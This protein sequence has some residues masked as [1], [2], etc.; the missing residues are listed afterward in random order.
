MRNE[1]RKRF[2]SYKNHLIA[3]VNPTCQPTRRS[4]PSRQWPADPWLLDLS[5]FYGQLLRAESFSGDP[6]CVWSGPVE[7]VPAGITH[8]GHS[9][10]NYCP[11]QPTAAVILTGER[12]GG[13]NRTISSPYQLDN[14]TSRRS[15][16]VETP[17][18]RTPR[19]SVHARR[20]ATKICPG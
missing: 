18:S 9:T 4:C 17:L 16:V 12:V 3:H 1:E 13:S 5:R 6:R 2:V 7:R 20:T 8:R 11:L 19:E 15:I 10:S 14:A